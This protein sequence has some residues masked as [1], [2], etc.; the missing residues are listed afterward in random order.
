MAVE[1]N[2]RGIIKDC[3]VEQAKE[4]VETEGQYILAD[5]KELGKW[6]NTLIKKHG[7]GVRVVNALHGEDYKSQ[8][9]MQEPLHIEVYRKIFE[10]RD[11]DHIQI[12][13]VYMYYLYCAEIEKNR[14]TLGK[15]K[16]N[17]AMREWLE[18]NHPEIYETKTPAKWINGKSNE[19]KTAM[20]LAKTIASTYSSN[21][22]NYY[23]INPF[24]GNKLW[25]I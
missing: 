12:S 15:Q 16:F 24:N 5:I 14:Y 17:Q 2:T 13:L 1:L 11:F 4:W 20:V 7:A 22:S 21:D 18:K 19:P 10:D 23:G 6:M 9:A 8:V 3:T 25:L